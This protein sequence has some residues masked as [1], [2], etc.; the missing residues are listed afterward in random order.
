MWIRHAGWSHVADGGSTVGN[1]YDQLGNLI[2]ELNA[3]AP[4]ISQFF[5]LTYLL[6]NFACFSLEISRSPGWRPS[7][8]YF[9]KYTAGFGSLLCLTI[10]FLLNWAYALVACLV[11]GV[12][13]SY[14]QYTDPEVNWGAAPQV[15]CHAVD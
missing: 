9:N 10:M 3:I 12:L 15:R 7:F 5:M 14:V 1:I 6:I 11:A 13:Y 8:S 4:L 2:G